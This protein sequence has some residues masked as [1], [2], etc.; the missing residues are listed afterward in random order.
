M[1]RWSPRRLIIA[2]C[3]GSIVVAATVGGLSSQ[4]TPKKPAPA[5]PIAV[6]GELP[7]DAPTV[8]SRS[9]ARSGDIYIYPVV[10]LADADRSPT[11]ASIRYRWDAISPNG[12][13]I[14]IWAIPSSQKGWST[15]WLI[16][17]VGLEF[18][19]KLLKPHNTRRFYVRTS[20]LRVHPEDSSW[21]PPMDGGPVSSG[22]HGPATGTFPLKLYRGE[23][24]GPELLERPPIYFNKSKWKPFGFPDKPLAT[25]ATQ[26]ELSLAGCSPLWIYPNPNQKFVLGHCSQN[27]KKTYAI[28]RSALRALPS[29]LSKSWCAPVTTSAATWSCAV[30]ATADAPPVAPGYRG[31][32]WAL[33][34]RSLLPTYSLPTVSTDRGTKVP[35]MWPFPDG[36]TSVS[37][38]IK[39][40]GSHAN[41]LAEVQRSN[42]ERLLVPLAAL[43]TS[44]AIPYC[45][46]RTNKWPCSMFGPDLNRHGRLR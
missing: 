30:R 40:M 1:I 2:A 12:Q 41:G 33:T 14:S 44:T 17:D 32:V 9:L 6:P 35:P 29:A 42:G 45:Y 37:G 10:R 20:D 21:S 43:R 4:S 31:F 46:S 11:T 3:I 7:A 26:D 22:Y 36:H 24:Y 15:G 19:H 5:S 16:S 28:E 8:A 39:M 25:A 13:P 18:D 34:G 38:D 23:S 27:G